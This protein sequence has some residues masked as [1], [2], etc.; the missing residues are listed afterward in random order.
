MLSQP[1]IAAFNHLLASESWA[2]GALAAHSGKSARLSLP[3]FDIDIAVLPEGKIATAGETPQT[4]VRANPS[5]L[6]R[7]LNGDLAEI[8]IRGDAEFAKTLGFLFRNL[9]WD[10][11]A[12]LGRFAGDIVA[13][14]LAGAAG[15]F[16]SWQKDA[17]HR[18]FG[19][20]AEYWTEERPLLAKPDDVSA[21]VS[22]VDRLR[23]DTARLEKRMDRLAS[24]EGRT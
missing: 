24:G 21:F 23:D 16:V 1:F 17:V 4:L 11:E 10:I 12:D 7:T 3:P 5:T 18:L 22:E 20:L 13:H 8:E 14:R 19:N 2:R 9:R 15:S 6:F